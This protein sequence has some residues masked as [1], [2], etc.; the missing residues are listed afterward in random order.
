MKC[1]ELAAQIERIQ[2]DAH[3]RDVARLCLLL[4]NQVELIDRLR[5]PQRLREAC[6]HAGLRLQVAT[7]QHAAMAQELED[8]AQSD[9]KKFEQQQIWILVRAIK[10]QNQILEMYLGEPAMDV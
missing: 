1:H 3:P 5:N 9:P 8:L 2:P 4:A 10:V 7:D 6:N